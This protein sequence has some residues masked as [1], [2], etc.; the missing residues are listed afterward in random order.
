MHL[1]ELNMTSSYE[2]HP[3]W[4]E[5]LFDTIEID[6]ERMA[7]TPSQHQIAEINRRRVRQLDIVQ[8]FYCERHKHIVLVHSD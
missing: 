1:D 7:M 8:L 3:Q 2:D 6:H 4:Q 5:A